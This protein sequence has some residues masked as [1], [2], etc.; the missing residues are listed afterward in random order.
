MSSLADIQ[1][2]MRDAVV[3]GAE[4]DVVP[5]LEAGGRDP[6]ARLA[7]HRRHYE[8]SLVEALRRR[9]PGALWLVGEA[10]VCAAAREFVRRY[11]PAAPCIAEYGESFPDFL[12]RHPGGDGVPYL[13]SFARLE[14]LV[15]QVAQ[16]VDLP[17]LRLDDLSG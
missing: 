16:S 8:A 6:A 12:A 13:A 5:L 15:A 7:V 10:F 3:L 14:W 17:A 2:R 11:P 1:S 9:F 4:S